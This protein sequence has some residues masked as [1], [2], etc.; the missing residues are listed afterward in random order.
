MS[1]MTGPGGPG[2]STSV[3]AALCTTPGLY[4]NATGVGTSA[5]QL[6]Q[7]WAIGK[8]YLRGDVVLTAANAAALCFVCI[9]SGT[10]TSSGS[11]PAQG[12]LTTAVGAT[13]LQ[14]VKFN[15]GIVITNTHASQ[16][17]YVCLDASA[18]SSSTAI[19][20]IAAGQSLSVPWDVAPAL[21]NVFGSGGGTTYGLVAQP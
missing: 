8:T 14:V 18:T 4:T 5:S 20:P 9:S 13:W 3:I 19:Y 17:M 1:A 21:L 2:I 11:A 10:T 15:N 7:T 16:T 6:F 12:S